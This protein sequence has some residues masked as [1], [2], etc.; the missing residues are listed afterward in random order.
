MENSETGSSIDFAKDCGC[1]TKENHTEVAGLC[2]E[3]GKMLGGMIGNPAPFL[4]RGQTS[5][6]GSQR[7]LTSAPMHPCS[8]A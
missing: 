6:A 4:I 5:E 7:A 1:I 3:I 2:Q 8:R